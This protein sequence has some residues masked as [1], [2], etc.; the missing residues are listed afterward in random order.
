MEKALKVLSWI[1]VVLGALAVLQSLAEFEIYGL[2]G[3]GLFFSQGLL[4][5]L[6]IDKK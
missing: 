5:L 6:Y 4:A 3:G 1:C 2:I